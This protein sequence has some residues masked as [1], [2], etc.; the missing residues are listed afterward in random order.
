MQIVVFEFITKTTK[1]L[2]SYVSGLTALYDARHI[3]FLKNKLLD[4][5]ISLS[6]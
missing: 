3:F 6:S 1:T 4:K 5:N 2:T